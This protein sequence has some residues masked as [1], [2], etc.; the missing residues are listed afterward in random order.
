MGDRKVYL[1]LTDTG[2]VLTRMIK[3]YTRQC[4]N[5][6]SIGFDCELTEVYSFG[7][8]RPRNPFFA[9]FVK[10]DIRSEL[11]KNASCA[12]YVFTVNEKTYNK[13]L[14][15]IKEMDLNRQKY[16]Y[17]LLGLFA[18]AINKRF[19]REHAFF[20][21]HFVAMVLKEGQLLNTNKHL[22]MITPQDLKEAS[23]HRLIYQGSL[24][25]YISYREKYLKAQ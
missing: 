10:E 25:S 24:Q 19:D 12:V 6:A 18:I 9:G 5:H 17:N 8:K 7:R 22:S 2:T 3:L 23:S 20:C 15:I 11:F 4:H 16:R 13:M 1:L 21:S 14:N